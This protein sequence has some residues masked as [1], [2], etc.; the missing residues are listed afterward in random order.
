M[1]DDRKDDLKLLA[2]YRKEAHD[3]K[4]TEAERLQYASQAIQEQITIKGLKNQAGT[5]GASV[6]DIFGEAA[7]EFKSFGSNIAKRGGILSGQDARAS[8][9]AR[10]LSTHTAQ[11]VA[12]VLARQQ[13]QRDN[14]RLTEAQ[15]Q[16]A[17][18][19]QIAHGVNK[20]GT[21]K[22]TAAAIRARNHA[23]VVAG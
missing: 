20:Y 17:L 6:A 4:L 16:T 11:S 9:A 8:F 19:R 23:S 12:Q 15:R 3:A 7:N 1:A 14:E 22:A 10:V 5:Q 2:F 13:A 21:P 18:L